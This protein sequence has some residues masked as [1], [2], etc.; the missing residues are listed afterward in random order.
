[1]AT[2][3]KFPVGG[4]R[5]DIAQEAEP[6]SYEY[7]RGQQIVNGIM[8]DPELNLSGVWNVGNILLVTIFGLLGLFIL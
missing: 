3:L 6:L 4:K 5:G 8:A 1:M 7:Y 2:V